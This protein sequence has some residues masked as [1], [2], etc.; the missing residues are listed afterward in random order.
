[1]KSGNADEWNV[2]MEDWRA[3]QVEVPQVSVSDL[4]RR[5]RRQSLRLILTTAM[6]ALLTLSLLAF[7]VYTLIRHSGPVILIWA[8]AVWVFL[9]VAWSFALWNRRGIWQPQAQTTRT[10]VE[11]LYERCLRK[12][13]TV[14]FCVYLMVAEVAFL[15]PW[16]WWQFR[17]DP[18][19]LTSHRS[20][21]LLAWG[22]T[23]LFLFGCILWVIWVR[24]RTFKDLERLT[25]LRQ[26]LQVGQELE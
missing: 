6:E 17:S 8:V 2:L 25:P 21:Y 20:T 11:L 10:L 24:R 7:S 19:A 12:L 3:G 5:V 13:L 15:I 4:R 9:L 16:G 18:Q 22:L 26:S 14:R 23:A 1:M